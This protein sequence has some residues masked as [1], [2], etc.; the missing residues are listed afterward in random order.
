MKALTKCHD[1]IVLGRE[2]SFCYF[3][4]LLAYCTPFK[5]QEFDLHR[6]KIS[7]P[8]ALGVMLPIAFLLLCSYGK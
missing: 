4:E 2:I 7:Q 1:F 3:A 5:Q 8:L 6:G